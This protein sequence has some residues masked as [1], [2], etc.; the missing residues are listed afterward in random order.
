MRSCH[1]H[2]SNDQIIRLIVVSSACNIKREGRRLSYVIAPFRLFQSLLS[3]S[4]VQMVSFL[5]LLWQKA[6]ETSRSVG[7]S[8][9]GANKGNTM[10]ATSSHQSQHQRCKSES[11]LDYSHNTWLSLIGLLRPIEFFVTVDHFPV[12]RRHLAWSK[13][14]GS[15]LRTHI[16][17]RFSSSMVFMSLLLGAELG[18]LFNSSEIT[19]EMRKS[20]A[21]E[22]YGDYKFWVGV[23]IILSVCVTITALVATFTAWGMVSSISDANMRCVIRSSI[24][25]YVTQLPTHLV[26]CA[27]YL[28][29]LWVVL[30]LVDMLSGVGRFIILVVVATLFF[31]VVIAYSA[32]G[33]LIVHTGAM[34]KKA[35]LS[36]EL[37]QA[38]L[39][40]GLH[41]SLLLRATTRKKKHTSVISQYRTLQIKTSSRSVRSMRRHDSTRSIRSRPAGKL[42]LSRQNSQLSLSSN[43]SSKT[44][45]RRAAPKEKIPEHDS[46]HDSCE[47]AD[48][49]EQ[50]IRQTASAFSGSNPISGSLI[51]T[52]NKNESDSPLNSDEQ[53]QMHRRSSSD[54]SS[55]IELTQVFSRPPRPSPTPSTH[56]EVTNDTNESNIFEIV[57]DDEEQDQD[58]RPRN[59]NPYSKRRQARLSRQEDARRES[60]CLMKSMGGSISLLQEEWQNETD[61]RE[62]YNVPPPPDL[63]SESDED[64]EDDS[65]WESES[66]YMPRPSVL[67]RHIGWQ[68]LRRLVSES[69]ATVDESLSPD[70]ENGVDVGASPGAGETDRLLKTQS[71]EYSTLSSK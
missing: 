19:S 12:W 66:E 48:F 52:D 4:S 5:N 61:A 17:Q 62:I 70:E 30:F 7:G 32:F 58:N 60:M 3:L 43:A 11:Q 42:S 9:P 51:F 54:S 37:E 68:S 63:P 34:G 18:V 29:L 2:F 27:L 49:E 39:P 50:L 41:A 16:M 31:Q 20:M 47:L 13:A 40:S 24:G 28:F 35:V 33:R 44:R 46:G 25:Q 1:W 22:D 15:D 14:T 69:P 38:L 67:N 8:A 57:S 23:T 65:D 26:V 64:E 36:P 6:P 45:R 71:S 10:K 53:K 21:N 59:K 56:K 55:S